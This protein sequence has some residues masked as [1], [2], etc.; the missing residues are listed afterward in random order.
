MLYGLE[1]YNILFIL[2]FSGVLSEP[3]FTT[4]PPNV[5]YVLSGTNVTFRWVYNNDDEFE[6]TNVQL[7]R[8]PTARS[9]LLI[10][11]NKVE[12]VRTFN[13]KRYSYV[14]PATFKIMNISAS[15]QDK[16]RIFIQSEK[17]QVRKLKDEM[18]LQIV[19]EYNF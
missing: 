3:Y 4:K 2:D 15:D 13:A 11:Y 1:K 7:T 19:S 9:R 17:V 14:P 6:I 10:E 12:K 16:Y 18:S 5:W 8:G